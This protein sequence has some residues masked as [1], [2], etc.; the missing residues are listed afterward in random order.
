M[1]KNR[2]PIQHGPLNQIQRRLSP[3][4]LTAA[5]V[6]DAGDDQSVAGNA[7]V[8][9]A[10]HGVGA[11]QCVARRLDRSAEAVAAIVAVLTTGAAYLPLDPKLPA[12]RIEFMIGDAAL[13]DHAARRG[14]SAACAR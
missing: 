13:A 2:P 6:A 10:G 4:A 8:V 11:G 1:R 12:T 5:I 7:E 9:L 14:Y 3:V